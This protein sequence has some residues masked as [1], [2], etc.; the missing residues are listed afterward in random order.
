MPGVYKQ[1]VSA[2]RDVSKKKDV[3]EISFVIILPQESQSNSNSPVLPTFLVGILAESF[4]TTEPSSLKT[5]T[6]TV[7]VNSL[8]NVSDSLRINSRTP[9]IRNNW[10]GAT[11][12][13]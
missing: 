11:T 12:Y 2:A 5:V 8:Q 6:S 4:L 13:R 10:D 9:I 1:C 7:Q 3:G